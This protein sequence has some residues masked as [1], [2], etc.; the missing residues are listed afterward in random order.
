MRHRILL[1]VVILAIGLSGCSE[2][3]APEPASEVQTLK[4][5]AVNLGLN[6]NQ[7]NVRE[8]QDLFLAKADGKDHSNLVEA[9]AEFDL[10]CT[11]EMYTWS[12][13]DSFVALVEDMQQVFPYQA[14]GWDSSDTSGCG[15]DEAAWEAY[16]EPYRACVHE[17]PQRDLLTCFNAPITQMGH[18]DA[19]WS[20]WRCTRCLTSTVLET[21]I[22]YTQPLEAQQAM[23]E[24]MDFSACKTDPEPIQC[25]NV[26][27]K[28]GVALHSKYPITKTDSIVFPFSWSSTRGVLYTE[29]DHPTGPIHAFCT[30]IA[31]SGTAKF[32]YPGYE[33]IT[34]S[35]DENAQHIRWALEYI[36]EKGIPES[37]SILFLGDINVGPGGGDRYTAD[38][39]DNYGLFEEAG[40]ISTVHADG[41][42]CT[43]CSD[44]PLVVAQYAQW[45]NPPVD[46]MS[47]HI[48]LKNGPWKVV[49]GSSGNFL[50]EDITLQSGEVTKWS[51][52]YGMRI[53]LVAQ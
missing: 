46:N 18:G 13:E 9:V 1:G 48:F 5:G 41:G 27:G 8:R 40:F 3:D 17:D 2:S 21:F 53:D 43:E 22:D 38:F 35:E 23:V 11:N 7:P 39:E 50:T 14:K 45:G 33:H 15:C 37:E 47:T 26:N 49:P 4:V 20:P 10:M 31:E 24:N 6:A 19:E 32:T 25:P 51:D 16:V 28:A 36:E 12:R 34:G 42:P 30:H 29:I 52:K 44:N